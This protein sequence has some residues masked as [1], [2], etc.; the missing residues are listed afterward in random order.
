MDAF[1]R[2]LELGAN[3]LES[4]AWLTADGIVVLDHDGTTGPLWRRTTI[5]AQTRSDL[6]G[7]IPSL[8]DLYER[9]GADFE[10]SLDLKDPAAL[11]AIMAVAAGAGAAEHLWLCH[12]DWRQM[13]GVKDLTGRAQLVESTSVSRIPEGLGQRVEALQRA[14]VAAVNLHRGE[15]DPDR[16]AAVHAAGLLAFGWDAQSARH[17]SRL[18]ELGLD[19]IYSDHVDRLVA[20]IAAGRPD[21][22]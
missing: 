22:G 11:A 13:A 18:L 6:P 5:S 7:H 2:A 21:S 10:L 4:D 3:G 16:V 14:G 12:H 15:W 1:L 8:Q 20:T 19:G 17:I 9:C